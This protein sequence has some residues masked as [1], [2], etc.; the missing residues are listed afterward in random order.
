MVKAHQGKVNKNPESINPNWNESKAM[1]R[2]RWVK[3]Q[4]DRKEYS[5][6]GQ[7]HLNLT[8]VKLNLTTYNFIYN[9]S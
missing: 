4:K 6:E 3:R 7:V 2:Q 9:P 5:L 1:W 8:A